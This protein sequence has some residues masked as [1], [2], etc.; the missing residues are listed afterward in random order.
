M[1]QEQTFKE[2]QGEWALEKYKDEKYHHNLLKKMFDKLQ[3]KY[4][5]LVAQHNY[6]NHILSEYQQ[7][8]HEY[9]KT[10]EN[11]LK[12][13]EELKLNERT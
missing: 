2:A 13:I 5:K 10:N 8:A 1:I 9:K 4:H 3:L 7:I 11:L 12:T 6:D